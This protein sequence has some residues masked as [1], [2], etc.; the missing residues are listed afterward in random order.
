MNERD[1]LERELYKLDLAK[2]FIKVNGDDL[3]N[4][5]EVN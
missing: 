1:H 5:C 2:S 4:Y 3:Y